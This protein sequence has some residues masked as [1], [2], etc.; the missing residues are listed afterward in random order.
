VKPIGVIPTSNGYEQFP[1]SLSFILQ[2]YC[3]CLNR[4]GH[5]VMDN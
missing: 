5:M 2:C 4:S 1:F 3:R